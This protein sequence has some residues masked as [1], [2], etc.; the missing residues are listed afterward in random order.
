M[1]S[2]I[3]TPRAPGSR[4]VPTRSCHHVIFFRHRLLHLHCPLHRGPRVG[5]HASHDLLPSPP[6]KRTFHVLAQPDISSATDRQT[7]NLTTDNLILTRCL[8]SSKIR[9]LD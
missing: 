9:L 2:T 3:W 1:G 6:A 7:D 4:L 5:L 8:I